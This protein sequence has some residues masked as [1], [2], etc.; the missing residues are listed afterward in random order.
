M[1]KNYCNIN[2]LNLY[3]DTLYSPLKNNFT[4][5]VTGYQ[6]EIWTDFD[7]SLIVN[8]GEYHSS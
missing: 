6:I 1:S 4:N 5:F 8:I 3:W 7:F 2:V